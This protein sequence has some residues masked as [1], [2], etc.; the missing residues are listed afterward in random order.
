MTITKNE[1]S[2][3]IPPKSLS[4]PGGGGHDPDVYVR[5]SVHQLKSFRALGRM[6]PDSSIL[7]VGCG[8][9]NMALAM[10]SFLSERGSYTGFDLDRDRISWCQTAY[11]DFKNFN[12]AHSDVFNRHYNSAGSIKAE[13]FRFPYEDSQFDFAI[14]N[15]VFTHMLPVEMENYLSEISRVLAPGGSIFATFFLLNMHSFTAIIQGT[16]KFQFKHPI[17]GA[18]CAN[19]ANPELAIA[20]YEPD[21]LFQMECNRFSS[22]GITYGNWACQESTAGGQDI[23]VAQK[24][25]S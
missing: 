21:V 3:L 16:A 6:E 20:Y 7:E 25:E 19:P 17:S 22:V 15:S 2:K 9:G 23:I 13:N 4:F 24:M 1:F 12:F 5:H 18:L 14:L 11:S 10:T 8:T